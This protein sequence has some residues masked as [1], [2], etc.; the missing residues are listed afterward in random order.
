MPDNCLL[1]HASSRFRDEVE[2]EYVKVICGDREIEF[3]SEKLKNILGT[4]D[5]VKRSQKFHELS[6]EDYEKMIH[7]ASEVRKLIDSAR[8][9]PFP[10]QRIVTYMDRDQAFV[11]TE[12]TVTGKD[13]WVIR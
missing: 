1:I 8:K 7:A 11:S 3:F 9:G 2:E 6:D 5:D 13:K 4:I 10:T 12:G